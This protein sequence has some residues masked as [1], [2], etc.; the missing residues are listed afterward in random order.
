MQVSIHYCYCYYYYIRSWVLILQLENLT[1]AEVEGTMQSFLNQHQS[2]P[3]M[4]YTLW[5]M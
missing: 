4:M 2:N 3:H 1:N 5:K